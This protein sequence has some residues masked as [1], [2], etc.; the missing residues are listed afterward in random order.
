[1]EQ[2]DALGKRIEKLVDSRTMNFNMSAS[3]T[4]ATVVFTYIAKEE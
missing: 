1:M 4:Y 3:I 2:Y